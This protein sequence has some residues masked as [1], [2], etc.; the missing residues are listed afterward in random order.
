M[1]IVVGIYET[2][3]ALF[4]FCFPRLCRSSLVRCFAFPSAKLA[5][6][7]FTLLL[8]W[9]VAK[10]KT[11]DAVLGYGFLCVNLPLPVQL[12][13]GHPGKL[14]AKPSEDTLFLNTFFP[15]HKTAQVVRSGILLNFF[16]ENISLPFALAL[17]LLLPC[18]SISLHYH[19]LQAAW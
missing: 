3:Y 6:L 15:V 12:V 11:G 17:S 8:R 2:D 18:S 5:K 10:K 19:Y 1:I 13:P 14:E 9:M 4:V 16:I 7:H